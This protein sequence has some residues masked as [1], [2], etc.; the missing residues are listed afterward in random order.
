MNSRFGQTTIEKWIIFHSTLPL[1]K[2]GHTV[3]ASFDGGDK[4][5]WN[6]N[7]QLTWKNNYTKMY[8]AGAARMIETVETFV[9]SNTA[10]RMHV[11]IIKPLDPG[12]VYLKVIVDDGDYEQTYLKMPE[13]PYERQ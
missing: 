2:G 5:T 6:I 12:V 11:L 9:L 1:K 8:P 10:D 13:S 3:A 7:E 4:K